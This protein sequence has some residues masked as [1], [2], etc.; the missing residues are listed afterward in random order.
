MERMLAQE[1]VVESE[2]PMHKWERVWV[3]V[4]ALSE[5]QMVGKMAGK[6][7]CKMVGWWVDKEV[8]LMVGW[9][10]DKEVALTAGLKEMRSVV[11]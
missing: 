4:R 1:L 11:K 7:V 3:P 9:W 8:A 6:M 5:K 2:Y 10:V